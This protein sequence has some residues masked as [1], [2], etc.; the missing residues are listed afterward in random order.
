MNSDLFLNYFNK[1]ELFLKAEF[2]HNQSFTNMV[3][4]SR[5]SAVKRYKDDL[6]SYAE[7]RNANTTRKKRI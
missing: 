2:S 7:L 5:N 6:L 4:N 1:I 3:K